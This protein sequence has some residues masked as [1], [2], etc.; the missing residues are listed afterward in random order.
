MLQASTEPPSL[1]NRSSAGRQPRFVQGLIV[2]LGLV[3]LFSHLGYLPLDTR[4][5]EPRRAL[6]ALEMRLS[7]DYITPTLNG[8]PYFNKPPLYN[9]IIA[10]SYWLFGSYS[11]LALRLPML[12]SLLGFALTVYLVVRRYVGGAVAFA[13]ALMLI[14]NVRILLY[15]SLLGLIDTTFSWLTYLAFVLVYHFDG[16]EAGRR[17]NHTALFLSTYALTAVGFLMK[18]LPSLV[19]QALTLLAWF[20]YTRQWR[21][22]LRPAH[23][24]GIGLFLA[25][26]GLY[27]VAYFTRNP[28]PVENVA[29]VL[30][31]ESAKRTVVQF[32]IGQTLL[33]L[34]TFPFEML[35]H[36]APWLTA[37]LLLFRRDVRRV[38]TANR[39]VFFN[40]LTFAVN[41]VIYW[42][43]PQVYAR[44]LIMFL[45]LL[46]TALAYVYYHHTRPTDP[47]RRW[48]EGLWLAAAVLITVGSWVPVL[49]PETRGL[50]GVGWKAGVTFTA[51]ALVTYGLFRQPS[52]RLVFLILF[53]VIVRIGF[54]WFVLPGRLT[55]RLAYK[56]DSER[57]ARLTLGKPLYGYR[58]TIGDD[59]SKDVNSFHIAALRGDILRLTDQKYPG[60]YYIADSVHLAGETYRTLDTIRLFD[61]QPARLVQFVE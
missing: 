41:F 23:W 25:L 44:Y 21:A 49:L 51:L 11:S 42:S 54:N 13:A 19:F 16:A 45:P 35:Y 60:A 36:F 8:V 52:N 29:G 6:V 34:L 26:T 57:I 53:M 56:E 22:L 27:Y 59:G 39:F 28:I 31:R 46:F 17:K 38:L 55:T 4:S 7:G 15:D 40:L 43:S 30:F 18:G 14:T 50:P 37:V 10:G 3:A 61:N 20:G 48:L 2:V 47:Q 32:G 33:H 1:S 5:D 9:W 24:L 12:L 58:Q